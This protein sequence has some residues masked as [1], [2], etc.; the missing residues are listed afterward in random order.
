MKRDIFKK[1]IINNAERDYSFVKERDYP[2]DLEI[3]KIQTLIGSRR[4]GKTHILFSLMNKIMQQH[5]KEAAMYINFEDDRL[6]P[7]QSYDLDELLE[8][9]YELYPAMRSRTAYFFFDEV[10]QADHWE[11][12]VRRVYDTENCR[13]IITGSSAKLLSMEIATELRG[14]CL[15]TEVF[16]LSFKEFLHFKN[17]AYDLKKQSSKTVSLLQNQLSEYILKGGFPE[18]VNMPEIHCQPL[19]QQYIDLIIYRDIVER[20]K[21]TNIAMLKHLI[22]F[23]LNNAAGLVSY[24]KLYNDLRSQG[25]VV[26]RNTVYEYMNHLED[27]FALFTVPVFSRSFRE[28]ARNPRKIYPA[29]TGLRNAIT[30]NSDIG[31]LYETVVFLHLRRSNRQLYYLKNKQE[32][33]FYIPDKKQLI[34]VSY[35]IENTKTFYREING[36]LE[37]MDVTGLTNATLINASKD[38]TIKK[39]NKTIVILPLWKWLLET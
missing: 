34:N 4:C 23:C 29:D 39:D 28:Q 5:G 7:I 27:C 33:D 19:L 25:L 24:N 22:K 10:Q 20:Y 14:R 38:E 37:A 16:P 3:N 1:I 26:A 35:D 17:I 15:T 30:L 8:A 36:L 12:F 13:I 6:F 31:R 21:V 32:T 11:L 9:Y 2:I 18:L